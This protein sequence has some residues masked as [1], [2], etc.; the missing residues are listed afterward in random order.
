MAVASSRAPRA[1]SRQSSW[2]GG[3]EAVRIEGEAEAGGGVGGGRKG[4]VT[5]TVTML[6]K[7]GTALNMAVNAQVGWT[8][9]GEGA[10]SVLAGHGY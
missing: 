5:E 2:A 6:D 3:Q 4:Y 9:C 10:A 1:F 8:M 7:S